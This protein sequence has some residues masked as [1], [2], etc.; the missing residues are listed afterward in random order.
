MQF[1]LSSFR[2]L[3]LL[4]YGN[5]LNN[6][7]IQPIA[8]RFQLLLQVQILLGYGLVLLQQTFS[9]KWYSTQIYFYV[10]RGVVSGLV[11][12]R[13]LLHVSL[14]IVYNYNIRLNDNAAE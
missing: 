5:P 10:L 1:H 8:E 11:L 9:V 4:L 7:N 12:G 14:N 6:L 3:L 2:V 13:P